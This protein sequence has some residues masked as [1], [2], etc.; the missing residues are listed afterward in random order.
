M[1]TVSDLKAACEV[2]EREHGSN[3]NIVIQIRDAEGS[4]INGTYVESTS[5]DSSGTLYLRGYGR[6]SRSKTGLH[7]SYPLEDI[8]KVIQKIR[9]IEYDFYNTYNLVVSPDMKEQV[10]NSVKLPE[11]IKLMTS[12]FVEKNKAYLLKVGTDIIK[13]RI[14]FDRREECPN[15]DEVFGC[16]DCTA[17]HCNYY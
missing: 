9:T 17:E 6:G 12:P 11:N 16:A 5:R 1:L 8:E 4:L 15:Y 13:P 10:K 2:I 14:G 7:H 3:G